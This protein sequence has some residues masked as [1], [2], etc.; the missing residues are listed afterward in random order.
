MYQAGSTFTTLG[1]VEPTN[2]SSALISFL[3]AFLGLVVIAVFI[4]YLLSLYGMYS[5]RETVMAR[6]SSAAG[7]PA[8][9]PEILARAATLERDP[10]KGFGTS[11]WI[12]WI[13]QIRMNTGVNPVLALFRSTSADRHWV[14]SMLAVIDTAAMRLSF[15]SPETLADDINAVTQ[16]TVTFGHLNHNPHNS[17]RIESD[18]L[19]IVKDKKPTALPASTAGLTEEELEQ[20]FNILVKLGIITEK[21]RKQA[22]IRFVRIRAHYF[23]DAYHLAHKHHAIR[24]PWSGDRKYPQDVIY[25]DGATSSLDQVK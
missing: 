4:G 5:D 2:A 9:A 24:A 6:L 1:I 17:W 19:E 13:T 8:W 11:S 15:G 14:V 3:A 21:E 18:L 22:Q 12:D 16:G 10:R 25:P 23:Q 20:G 7:E